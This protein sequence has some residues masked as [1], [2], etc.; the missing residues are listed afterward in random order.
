MYDDPIVKEIRKIREQI[1]TECDFDMEKI[2]K[3]A[4]EISKKYKERIVTIQDLENK[5]EKLVK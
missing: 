5:R 1:S 3:R 4:S 2:H